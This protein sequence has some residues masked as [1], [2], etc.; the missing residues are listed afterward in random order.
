MILQRRIVISTVF[1]LLQRLIHQ[2]PDI[3]DTLV[4]R[5]VQRGVALVIHQRPGHARHSPVDIIIEILHRLDRIGFAVGVDFGRFCYGLFHHR[6]ERGV[7]LE[8]LL[9]IQ[10][11]LRA[12]QGRARPGRGSGLR[13]SPVISVCRKSKELKNKHHSQN[14]CQD[15]FCLWRHHNLLLSESVISPMLRWAIRRAW[16]F[17]VKLKLIL[18]NPPC[19]DNSEMG[20]RACPDFYTIS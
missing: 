16:G 10:A 1:Q 7:G 12:R 6:H 9:Q 5:A 2:E 13:V 3:A 18:P 20:K 11:R 8:Q 15:L 19:I 14:H 4:D 17:I